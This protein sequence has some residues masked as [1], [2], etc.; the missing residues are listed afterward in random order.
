M[1][2]HER[3]ERLARKIEDP[4]TCDWDALSPKGWWCREPTGKLHI[5]GA[6][7]GWLIECL[8]NAGFVFNLV[9]VDEGE[10]VAQLFRFSDGGFIRSGQ[11]GTLLEAVLDA[12]EWAVGI[13]HD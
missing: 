3:I 12:A 11:G 9:S 8:V 5:M 13:H 7:A 6:S 1:K 2:T 10:C 4:E